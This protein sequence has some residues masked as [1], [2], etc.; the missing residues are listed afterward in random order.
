MTKKFFL[1]VLCVLCGESLV[2]F[3]AS[4]VEW[5]LHGAVKNETASPT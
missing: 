3:P 4:A 2:A 1:C 5:T